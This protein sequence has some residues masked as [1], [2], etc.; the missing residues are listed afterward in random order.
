MVSLTGFTHWIQAQDV[1]V[2]APA[3]CDFLLL[4]P[5]LTGYATLMFP[6]KHQLYGS[7]WCGLLEKTKNTL[8]FCVIWYQL[9][10]NINSFTVKLLL[11]RVHLKL[12]IIL[13]FWTPVSF[14][15][16]IDQHQQILWS[17]IYKNTTWGSQETQDFYPLCAPFSITKWMTLSLLLP[18]SKPAI[19]HVKKT[20]SNDIIYF[21]KLWFSEAVMAYK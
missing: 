14:F 10:L 8:S 7:R 13:L 9:L 3:E 15:I 17:A 4:K 20:G 18:A 6:R 1:I 21:I 2:A 19:F 16:C 11:F 12:N 5:G